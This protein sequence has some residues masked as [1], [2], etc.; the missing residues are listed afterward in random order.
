ML[1]ARD[2]R[3]GGLRK[4]VLRTGCTVVFFAVLATSLA[5][6]SEASPIG[7]AFVCAEDW[8]SGFLI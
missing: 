4:G 1:L 8:K 6:C 2:L 7:S 5:L 3:A